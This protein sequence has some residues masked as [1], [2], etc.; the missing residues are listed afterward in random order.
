MQSIKF[1]ISL[2][3]SIASFA[4]GPTATAEDQPNF[5]LCR[6]QKTVRTVRIDKVGDLYVTKYTQHGVDKEVGRGRNRGSS[7]KI[8]E[9]IKINLEKSNWKCKELSN[10]SFTSTN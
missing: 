9:N 7:L 1:V 3:L 4:V 10:V 8:M 6:N 2:I 5:V